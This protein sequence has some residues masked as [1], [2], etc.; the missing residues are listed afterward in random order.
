MHI[1][2][3][4]KFRIEKIIKR[5]GNKLYVKW[6]AYIAGKAGLIKKT[7]HKIS[8][9]FPK[10][11]HSLERN[12]KVESDLSSYAKTGVDTSKLAAKS[13]LVSLTAKVDKIDVYK[14]K[15]IPVDFSKL[16]NA[17]NNNVVEMRAILKKVV[18]KI[19]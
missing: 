13:D 9:Y 17:V 4:E 7:M 11:Y 6:K 2:N 8:Q 14:L 3:Q 10:P 18:L 16:S 15:T 5:K 12:V 19:I 1:T